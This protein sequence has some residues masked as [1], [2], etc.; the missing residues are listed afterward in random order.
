[1]EPHQCE[2]M[3][4]RGSDRYRPSRCLLNA[5]P[6]SLFCWEHRNYIGQLASVQTPEVPNYGLFINPVFSEKVNTIM[7]SDDDLIVI[8]NFLG[9]DTVLAG[10]SLLYMI[11]D[12]YKES[13]QHTLEPRELVEYLEKIAILTNYNNNVNVIGTGNID[14]GIN[15]E[16]INDFDIYTEKSLEE[17]LAYFLDHGYTH[18]DGNN[19]FGG[20]RGHFYSYSGYLLRLTGPF[21]LDIIFVTKPHVTNDGSIEN[22]R[23]EMTSEDFIEREFD[24]RMCKTWYDGTNVSSYDNNI[25]RDDI[26]DRIVRFSFDP[27]MT[28]NGHK[29]RTTAS[30]VLKYRSRGFK[31]ICDT[32]YMKQWFKE[33][34]F[35]A[36]SIFIDDHHEYVKQLVKDEIAY[37]HADIISIEHSNQQYMR[38]LFHPPSGGNLTEDELEEIY[39]SNAIYNNTRSKHPIEIL[40]PYLLLQKYYKACAKHHILE[41]EYPEFPLKPCEI[42]QGIILTTIVRYCINPDE[43]ERFVDDCDSNGIVISP[44]VYGKASKNVFLHSN[45]V[46]LATIIHNKVTRHYELPDYRQAFETTFKSFYAHRLND[47][48]EI[49]VKTIVRM[50]VGENQGIVQRIMRA[51]STSSDNLRNRSNILRLLHGETIPDEEDEPIPRVSHIN[52]PTMESI[53]DEEEEQEE[54]QEEEPPVDLDLLSPTEIYD[55][56]RDTP[57]EGIAKRLVF[58]DYDKLKEVCK[59]IND[60]YNNPSFTEKFSWLYNYHF[61]S[62]FILFYIAIYGEIIDRLDRTVLIDLRSRRELS[63]IR[64]LNR[65]HPSR[66]ELC[67]NIERDIVTFDSFR[68][69]NINDYV[70]IGMSTSQNSST[71][72]F[73][74]TNYSLNHYY[75]MLFDGTETIFSSTEIHPMIINRWDAYVILQIGFPCFIDLISFLDIIEFMNKPGESG[76]IKVFYIERVANN[77]LMFSQFGISAMHGE[78]GDERDTYSLGRIDY[79]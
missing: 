65:P 21:K 64:S 71:S 47:I 67:I 40:F 72:F 31:F 3:N 29:K 56:I 42:Q 4:Y 10:G 68:D 2:A 38:E 19:T 24:F 61:P 5:N 50:F 17:V 35:Q 36:M 12:G 51:Q 34:L 43:I 8:Q 76:K 59:L 70:V 6:D 62:M 28:L 13:I 54:E 11:T 25:T 57:S 48:S 46:A 32:E 7:R 23:D 33:L 22:D 55:M 16:Y 9:D 37:Y 69:M 30:R 26:R 77:I 45:C 60:S 20:I 14:G 53:S 49:D 15:I 44:Y 75:E 1:M 73:C 18:F 66:E 79:I 27:H 52:D 74:M 41:R 78:Q 58:G 63:T 39:N